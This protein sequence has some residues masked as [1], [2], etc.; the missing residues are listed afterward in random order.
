VECECE[1]ECE[2]ERRNDQKAMKE[3]KKGERERT[4]IL[5]GEHLAKKRPKM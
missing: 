2:C 4:R 1:C 3:T 5:I